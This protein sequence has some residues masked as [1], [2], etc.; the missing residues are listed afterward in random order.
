MSSSGVMDS[1][2]FGGVPPPV[3]GS[4][5]D[6]FGSPSANAPIHP[7]IN[8]QWDIP[9]QVETNKKGKEN[10]ETTD[11]AAQA[12]VPT[13]VNAKKPDP[14]MPNDGNGNDGPVGDA[15]A[16]VMNDV[17]PAYSAQP[18]YVPWI[19]RSGSV[20]SELGQSIPEL[21]LEYVGADAPSRRVEAHPQGYFTT[22]RLS[23]RAN[24]IRRQ[25]DLTHDRVHVSASIDLANRHGIPGAHGHRGQEGQVGSIGHSGGTG[26]TKLQ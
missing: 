5:F 19:D 15:A 16:G 4:G 20:Y 8:Q 14:P 3:S 22:H 11:D 23:R 21:P 17:P 2:T 18:V 24:D 6:E 10:D 7:N 25:C 1:S 12:T 13:T 26:E 9:G